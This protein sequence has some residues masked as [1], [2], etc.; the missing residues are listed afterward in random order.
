[1]GDTKKQGKRKIDPPSREPIETDNL[2]VFEAV[3]RRLMEIGEDLEVIAT[4]TGTFQVRLIEREAA[5][6]D[7]AEFLLHLFLFDKKVRESLLGDLEEQFREVQARFGKNRAW[8]WYYW[9]VTRSLWPLLVRAARKIGLWAG[10][11]T[12]LNHLRWYI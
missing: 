4:P 5:P 9:Q 7:R 2:D 3:L 6:P 12:V 8:F 10:I 11:G 1:M